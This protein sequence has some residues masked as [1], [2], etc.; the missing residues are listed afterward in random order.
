[1]LGVIL[2]ISE[3]GMALARQNLGIPEGDKTTPIFMDAFSPGGDIVSEI[4]KA[5]GIPVT[6]N[7]D[8]TTMQALKQYALSKGLYLS[9]LSVYAGNYPVTTCELYKS[10]GIPVTE[11]IIA[12]KTAGNTVT[13]GADGILKAVSEGKISLQCGGVSEGEKAASTLFMFGI[14]IVGVMGLSLLKSKIQG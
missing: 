5:L 1:M 7:Y 12:P 11:L 3:E 9:A 10:L 14:P 2:P 8:E 6:G 4:Q 13:P